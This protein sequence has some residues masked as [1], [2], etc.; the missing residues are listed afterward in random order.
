[1]HCSY[2]NQPGIE[3]RPYDFGGL[4]GIYSINPDLPNFSATYKPIIDKLFAVGYKENVDLFG[5]P[6]DFRLAAD[7]LDQVRHALK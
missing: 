4:R 6:Y 2:T 3:I 1:M 5:A 7:G